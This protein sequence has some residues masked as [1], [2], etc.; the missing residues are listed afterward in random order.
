MCSKLFDL[1]TPYHN[2][3][4]NSTPHVGSFLVVPPHIG[5]GSIFAL[6]NESIGI[7]PPQNHTGKSADSL[8]TPIFTSCSREIVGFRQEFGN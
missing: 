3:M 8:G 6:H 7:A 5:L 2:Q 4:D 1:N